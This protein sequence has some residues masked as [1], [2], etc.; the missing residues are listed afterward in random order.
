MMAWETIFA[1]GNL[2]FFQVRTVS[3]REGF[4]AYD[5]WGHQQLK[6]LCP[7][8]KVSR[9]YVAIVRKMR[10]HS[11]PPP[12]HNQVPKISETP[13]LRDS[14]MV[15]F[16]DF[17]GWFSMFFFSCW[18]Q[19]NSFSKGGES[20]IF[21]FSRGVGVSFQRYFWWHW[22]FFF[23]FSW[24]EPFPASRLLGVDL[25]S[26]RGIS[27][28]GREYFCSGFDESPKTQKISIFW[29]FPNLRKSTSARL[30][31]FYPSVDSQEKVW[32]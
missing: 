26:G 5:C 18:K 13:R 24:W 31:W 6:C 9:R 2:P 12:Q 27:R 17:F 21:F 30:W 15:T 32:P 29:A 19:T 22:T 16:F 11:R 20:R 8:R 23:L 1:F 28:W 4:H 3:F 10:H 25:R 7:L 14:L